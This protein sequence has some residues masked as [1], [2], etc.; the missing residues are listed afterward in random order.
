MQIK[1]KR[2]PINKAKLLRGLFAAALMGLTFGTVAALAFA[3]LFNGLIEFNS[4]NTQSIVVQSEADDTIDLPTEQP[5]VGEI[6]AEADRG[7]LYGVS[8]KVMKALVRLDVIQT[9]AYS[10]KK[11]DSRI[12]VGI[13]ISHNPK[14]VYILT[15]PNSARGKLTVDVT[16]SDGSTVRGEVVETDYISGLSVVRVDAELVK[17]AT[18]KAFPEI[19]F[20][21]SNKTAVGD[22][23]VAVG[24]INGFLMSAVVGNVSSIN[25]TFSC[26]DGELAMIGTDIPVNSCTDGFL[27][28]SIGLLCG[29]I[30][31]ENDA[32]DT[33]VNLLNA[34][35]CS[36]LTTTINKLS[37]GSHFPYIGIRTKTIDYA[38][39]TMYGIPLGIFVNGVDAESPAYYA[40]FMVGDII[41]AIGNKG[42]MTGRR[43]H[44]HLMGI[45]VSKNSEKNIEF[46]ILR[47]V[48]GTYEMRIINVYAE[49]RY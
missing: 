31:H 40:G 5:V 2:K 36:D 14:V 11:G 20:A 18:L 22:M 3:F 16:F 44:S 4:N 8:R 9:E 27:F 29:I 19:E 30:S 25:E 35:G 46:R 10:V 45:D 37:S 34:I 7:D 28:N 33:S 39:G 1:V 42:M 43:L 41:T 47:Q 32:V 26:T 12:K 24:N 13:V 38:T 17:P 15:T 21:N 48:N 23:V 6:G 49:E